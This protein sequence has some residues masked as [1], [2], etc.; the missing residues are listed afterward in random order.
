MEKAM[1]GSEALRAQNS[2]LADHSS[3]P[4][5]LDRLGACVTLARPRC[6]RSD[7]RLRCLDDN[8]RWRSECRRLVAEWRR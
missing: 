7:D 4:R 1:P 6:Y 5:I 3:T 2:P 8:C